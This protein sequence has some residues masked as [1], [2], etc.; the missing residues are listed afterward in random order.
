VAR[1]ATAIRQV[2]ESSHEPVILLDGGDSLF[3]G[4]EW[5]T[6]PDPNQGA[7]FVETMNAMGY[8]AIALG[9]R[10][11]YAPFSTVQARL[12]EVQFP[13]LSAN[14]DATGVLSNVQPYLLRQAGEH[15]VAIVGVTSNV[16]T[17][18]LEALGL[19]L[20]VQDPVAA[21]GAA[22]S[23]AVKQADIVILLSNLDRSSTEAVA[24]AVPGIDAIVGLYDG[25]QREP[26]ALPG[27]EG[28]VILHASAAQGQYLGVLTLQFDE[29]GQVV[30]Y[31]GRLLALTDRYAD[32]PQI[33]EIFHRY[34]SQQ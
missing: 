21:V 5:A 30:S 28:Q 31:A 1:R 18:R 23:E 20:T 27:A 9:E 19:D 25:E 17:K 32:D 34:A 29:R 7:L 24:Q 6:I 15:T 10:E 14:V 16:A 26:V 2:R 12:R 8:E 4:G 3:R 11:L 22:V 13:I 33:V